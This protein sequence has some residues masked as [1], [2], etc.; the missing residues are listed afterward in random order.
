MDRTLIE[1][2]IRKELDEAEHWAAL[3]R[4]HIAHQREVIDTLERDSHDTTQARE[5]LK[6]LLETQELH[7]A[8]VERLT[9]ELETWKKADGKG[10]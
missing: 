1:S 5:L 2:T 10:G 9:K 7:E 8:S 6:T 4:G 3:G